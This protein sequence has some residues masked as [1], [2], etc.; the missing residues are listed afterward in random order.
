MNTFG[1]RIVFE[2]AK[3]LLQA[4]QLDTSKAVLTQSSLRLEQPV[5]A[6]VT[7]YPFPILVNDNSGP[8]GTTFNTEKRLI[9][10]D[11]FVASDFG[12]FLAQPSSATDAT[13]SLYTYPSPTVFAGAG[14]A[15][16]LGT[17][18]NGQLSIAINNQIILPNWDTF[19]YKCVPETQTTAA[20]T[21]SLDQ[22]NA[23]QGFCIAEPNIV[24][25]GSRNNVINLNLPAAITGTIGATPQRIVIVVRGL[26]AQNVT[27]VN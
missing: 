25:S 2:N 24:L 4:A 27:S 23:E 19:R 12:M 14:L 8:S 13:F 21:P 5:T 26:R 11:A 9:L 22:Y 7:V 17:V 1:G 18:Y 10:Q 20:A 16:G 3:A 6:G 15:A